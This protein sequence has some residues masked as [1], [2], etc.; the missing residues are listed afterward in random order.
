[1]FAC[2]PATR[3]F[4]ALDPVDLRA[5]FNGLCAWVQQRLAQDALSGHLY[6]F[7]NRQRNRV[8]ILTWDGSGL[9]CCAK[10]LERGRLGWPQG[11]SGHTLLRAEE[12]TA[13]L[14]GLEVQER[15]GWYRRGEKCG[16]SAIS[17]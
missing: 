3:I 15:K 9:W 1:V 13:L 2:T 16:K 6:V 8:K 4:V 5:S 17:C 11:E 12:L 7:T 10:R 14:H